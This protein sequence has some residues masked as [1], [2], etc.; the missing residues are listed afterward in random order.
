[1]KFLTLFK[2]WKATLL[3]LLKRRPS[4]NSSDT[5]PTS[6]PARLVGICVGH[7]REKDL[8]ARSISGVPEWTF[9]VRVAVHIRRLLLRYGIESIIYDEYHGQGYTAAMTWLA[10]TL[11]ADGVEL[12]IELHF[13]AATESAAGC[14]MLYYQGSAPGKRLASCLQ[15]EVLSAYTT[16]DR[17]IKPV[18]RFSRGGAFLVKTKCPAVICEPFFGTNERDWEIF[19]Q[20]RTVLAKAYARGIKTFLSEVPDK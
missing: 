12:A 17:G 6:K 3:R 13:N 15:K 19:S 1:M 2:S 5:S 8:G 20:T 14:E 9:N 11:K 16:K 4:E 18:K 7:S 10:H